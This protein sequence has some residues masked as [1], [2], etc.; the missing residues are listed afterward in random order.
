MPPMRV[1]GDGG[2]AIW[3]NQLADLKSDPAGTDYEVIAAGVHLRY[4]VKVPLSSASGP[5]VGGLPIQRN[6]C[7]E[8]EIITF[9]QH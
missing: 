8:L 7:A 2:H 9:R 1:R 4:G 6:A 3:E 5:V